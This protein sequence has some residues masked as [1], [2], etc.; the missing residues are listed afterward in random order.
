MKKAIVLGGTEDHIR[1]IEI[2]KSKSCY[3]ILIDYYENPPAKKVA[4]EY[5]RESTLDNDLILNI[6]ANIKAD[7]VIAACIDQALLTMAFVCEKLGLPCHISYQTALELTNKSL[8]KKIF[9]ENNIP[10]SRYSILNNADEKFYEDFKYPLVVKPAD[11]NSSKGITKVNNQH[12]IYDAINKAFSY[13]RSKKVV[14]EEFV[15]GEELSVDVVIKNYEPQIVM[16]TK[17]IKSYQNKNNFTIV[18]SVFPGTEDNEVIEK[19]HLIACNIAK[20]YGISNGPLLIQLILNE[21]NLSVLEFSSRIGGGS[22]HHFIKSVTGFDILNYFTGLILGMDSTISINNNY[23]YAAI[24]YIYA[25]NGIINDFIGFEVLMKNNIINQYF[26]YKMSGASVYNHISSGD[27]IAGY[28]ITSNSWDEVTKKNLLA[29][30]N[31]MVTDAQGND[32]MLHNFSS[33]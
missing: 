28:L 27:R 25:K 15:V 2:L 4:D 19:I 30:I 23:K 18:Q 16:V 6:A 3:T 17:N 20:A 21:N 22:K 33:F 12:E 10:T 1:L 32:L 24:N 14:V 9:V 8:M 31:L 26:C 5:I 13:T 11:S 29:D 7:L